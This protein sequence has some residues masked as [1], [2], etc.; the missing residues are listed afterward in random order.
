MMLISCKTDDQKREAARL[1]DDDKLVDVSFCDKSV[2]Y[3][4]K[5]HKNRE[6]RLAELVIGSAQELLDAL[7]S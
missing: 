5:L 1:C 3:Y 6:P 2:R 4:C 7:S